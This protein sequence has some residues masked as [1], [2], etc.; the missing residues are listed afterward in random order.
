[1]RDYCAF[2]SSA[3]GETRQ[4]EVYLTSLTTPFLWQYC[5]SLLA[6]RGQPDLHSPGP[7][8]QQRDLTLEEGRPPRSN[9]KHQAL[10]YQTNASLSCSSTPQYPGAQ[11]RAGSQAAALTQM[12]LNTGAG[13]AG[14]RHHPP[15]LVLGECQRLDSILPPGPDPPSSSRKLLGPRLSTDIYLQI[16]LQIFAKCTIS[17]IFE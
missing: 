11:L 8:P 2:Q 15:C 5:K 1:M 4:I 10:L 13:P 3:P 16:H 17:P 12:L 6:M 7:L 14:D 9:T